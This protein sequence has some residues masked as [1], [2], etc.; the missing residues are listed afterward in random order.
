[1][2]EPIAYQREKGIELRTMII[3][4]LSVIIVVANVMSAV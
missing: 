2:H 3:A 1:M 4:S